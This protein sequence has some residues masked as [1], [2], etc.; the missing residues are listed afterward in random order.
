MDL[1]TKLETHTA[2]SLKYEIAQVKKQ[3]NYSKL[4][5]EELIKLMLKNKDLFSRITA[6]PAGYKH[7][8]EKGKRFLEPTK[9]KAQ[10][11]QVKGFLQDLDM[12]SRKGTANIKGRISSEENKK[13]AEKNYKDAISALKEGTKK[14]KDAV[15]D[16]FNSNTGG[17]EELKEALEFDRKFVKSNGNFVEGVLTK[18]LK[19]REAI[20]VAIKGSLSKEDFLDLEIPEEPKKY[21]V[22]RTTKGGK[23]LKASKEEI[24]PDG[25]HIHIDW[26]DGE[27][28][29]KK[30]KNAKLGESAFKKF[31]SERKEKRDYKSLKLMDGKKILDYSA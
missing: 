9:K 4:N 12:K 31:R 29:T 14:Q 7:I 27:K 6:V 21:K 1:K 5:K 10:E 13:K 16:F 28:E 19:L 25:I 18:P 17:N 20:M 22:T 23:V 11:D 2:R 3:F 15:I 8:F 24:H 30:Y 26:K